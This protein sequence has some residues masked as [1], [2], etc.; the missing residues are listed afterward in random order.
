MGTFWRVA[1]GVARDLPFSHQPYVTRTSHVFFGCCHIYGGGI[2][3]TGREER[4]HWQEV[5]CPSLML[6]QLYGLFC[7]ANPLWRP[8]GERGAP[9][10]FPSAEGRRSP[11]PGPSICL[12]GAHFRR[13]ALGKNAFTNRLAKWTND[14]MVSDP[15]E[16]EHQEQMVQFREM[17]PFGERAAKIPQDSAFSWNIS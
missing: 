9:E 13:E 16:A 10:G 8:Q 11:R 15:S 1:Q 3:L 2:I 4:W 5:S 12:A 7:R 6:P 17:A 14:R